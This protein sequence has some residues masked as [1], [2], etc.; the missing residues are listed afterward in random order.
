MFGGVP[1]ETANPLSYLLFF[2]NFDL[3]HHG[4]PDASVLGVLW[5]ISVEEQFYILWPLISFYCHVKLI[6]IFSR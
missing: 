4:L 5:S 3:I 1:D 2:A 6:R